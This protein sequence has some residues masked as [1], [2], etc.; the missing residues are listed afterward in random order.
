MKEIPVTCEVRKDLEVERC[1]VCLD[2]CC[3][4]IADIKTYLKAKRRGKA[5]DVWRELTGEDWK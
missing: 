2:K 4:G 5:K 1:L 3:R